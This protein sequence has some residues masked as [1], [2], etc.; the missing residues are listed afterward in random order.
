MTAKLKTA[1]ALLLILVL[2][3]LMVTA[4]GESQARYENT[5]VWNTVLTDLPDQVSSNYLEYND[6]MP[7]TVVLEEI[8]SESDVLFTEITLQSGV[9]TE[10]ALHWS[11]Y[12]PGW[13]SAEM[14]LNEQKLEDG[15][16][17]TLT[18]TPLK[19]TLKLTAADDSFAQ[20]R[21]EQVAEVK[22]TWGNTLEATF[23]TL[24]A[25]VPE[26]EP[27]PPVTEPVTEPATEPPADSGDPEADAEEQDSEPTDDPDES[28]ETGETV[29]EGSEPAPAAPATLQVEAPEAYPAEGELSLK[30]TPSW[31]VTKIR[32]GLLAITPATEE[33]NGS[34]EILPLPEF[35]RFRYA[36]EKMQY[37]LPREGILNLEFT[38]GTATEVLLD[39]TRT[40]L[41]GQ[42]LELVVLYYG[43]DSGNPVNLIPVSSMAQTA[44]PEYKLNER[45]LNKTN[46][47]TMEL[48]EQWVTV[49]TEKQQEDDSWWD[50]EWWN[51]SSYV[52]VFYLKPVV[53]VAK[54]QLEIS[55]DPANLP[56]PGRYRLT[57]R[58]ADG[59]TPLGEAQDTFFVIYS[60][61]TDIIETGGA[62]Q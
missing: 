56:L 7:L 17:L 41:A 48:P 54:G 30:L 38:P 33:E 59:N 20:P 51:G 3:A 47:I 53:N 62:E 9:K 22:V 23:R 24:L 61:H 36:G 26:P 18:E 42:N 44:A 35:T 27:E 34:I 4:V 31:G 45:V 58:A 57:I 32:L 28:G 1:Y 11:N 50:I 5:Q 40:S 19:L 43:E 29:P 12:H 14:Y 52:P 10:G 25:E 16:I 37:M 55:C 2:M 21:P 15:V 13:I 60:D 39:L 6:R 8:E 49:L 46:M